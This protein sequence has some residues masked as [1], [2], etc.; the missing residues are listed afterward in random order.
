V[1]NVDW[2]IIISNIAFGLISASLCA[3]GWNT[4]KA[5]KYMNVGKPF[6][7]PLLLSSFLFAI[8]SLI[9]ILND[10]FLSLTVAFEIE[11]ITQLIALCSL[12]VGIYSYSKMIKVNMPEK[13]IIPEENFTQKSKKSPYSPLTTSV[14]HKEDAS[15]DFQKSSSSECNYQLGYL[16]TFPAGAS[17]PEECLSCNKIM[18]CKQS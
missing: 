16:A 3:L 12:S 6:W 2:L 14:Y 1:V 13:N 17:F 18:E 8:S 10:A 9:T 15:N 5:I 4:L 7:I 11:Q